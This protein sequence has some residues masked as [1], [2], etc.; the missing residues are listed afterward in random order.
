FILSPPSV[1]AAVLSLLLTGC[2]TVPR[3]SPRRHLNS[4]STWAA[5][6]ATPLAAPLRTTI[7]ARELS[8]SLTSSASREYSA[9]L[10]SQ[11]AILRRAATLMAALQSSNV[12]SFIYNHLLF[13]VHPP[14]DN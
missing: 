6:N 3:H 9:T 11:L 2:A 10:S 4:S 5:K 1:S 13:L 14:G 8:S 7:L 12:S